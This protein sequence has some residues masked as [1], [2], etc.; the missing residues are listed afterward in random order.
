MSPE[1]EA[2][3]QERVAQSL[4]QL[5]AVVQLE[6]TRFLSEEAFGR[7]KKRPHF[8]AQT[9]PQALIGFRRLLPTQVETIVE[10]I[11]EEIRILRTSLGAATENPERERE[12]FA[13]MMKKVLGQAARKWL[14]MYSIPGDDRPDRDEDRSLDLNPTYKLSYEPSELLLWAWRQVRGIDN[15]HGQAFE[16]GA[17]QVEPTYEISVYLPEALPGLPV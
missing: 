8:R 12:S 4:G 2:L 9:P 5:R 11:G 17:G 13:K 3:I 7:L 10:Q 16:A 1:L 14:L 6:V 15:A